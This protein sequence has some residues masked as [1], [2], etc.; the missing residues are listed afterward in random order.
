MGKLHRPQSN[1]RG[2]ET[3]PPVCGWK[4]PGG[5]LNRTSVGLK[6]VEVSA[7]KRWIGWPQSNQR[8]IETLDIGKN[9]ERFTE[10]S[11]EPA[12]D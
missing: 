1:Q 9:D 11:I 8:G 6:P 3:V 2:I 5:R 4:G 12:W 10:A 7:A